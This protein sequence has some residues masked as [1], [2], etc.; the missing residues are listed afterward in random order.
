MVENTTT[1]HPGGVAYLVE[2][3]LDAITA[4]RVSGGMPAGAAPLGTALT[5]AQPG[6]LRTTPGAAAIGS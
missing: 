2:G 1:L 5:E 3:P 4:D 6:Q